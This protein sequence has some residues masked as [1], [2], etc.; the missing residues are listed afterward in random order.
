MVEG[1]GVSDPC[2]GPGA[3]PLAFLPLAPDQAR[4]TPQNTGQPF[5]MPVRALLKQV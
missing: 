5:W 4:R 1:A 3:K 2:W